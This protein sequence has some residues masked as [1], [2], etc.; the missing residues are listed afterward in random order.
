M[1]KRFKIIFGVFLASAV[2]L[3]AKISLAQD[4]G[5]EPVEST[6]ALSASDPRAIIGRIIQI[7]LSL[8]GVITLGLIIY[9][10]FLWMTSGGEEDKIRSAKN[11][12]RNAIIG[13]VIILSAWSITTFLLDRLMEAMTGGNGRQ[14]GPY[15]GNNFSVGLG[16]IGSCSV[17]SVYPE[18]NQ[19]DVPRNTSIIVTFK[20][21]IDA[22]S[23]CVDAS[24]GAC[25]CDNGA[26]SFINPQTIRIYKQELNDA[27]SN[28]CP[29]QNSNVTDVAVAISTDKRTLILSP[30]SYLGSAESNTDYAVKITSDLKKTDGSSMFRTCSA[31]ELI[32]G[33]EIG[34]RL[35]LTPPQVVSRSLFPRPDNAKDQV[36]AS[37]E[38][39]NA[40]AE[41]FVNNCPKI[42]VPAALNTVT[43]EAE[44]VL[45]YHG[46]I[47]R[48]MV[49]V[50][51]DDPN[52]AQL[53]N[54]NTNALLGVSEFNENNQVVFDGYFSLKVDGHEAGNSWEIEITPEQLADTLTVGNIKYIFA[55]TGENN[56]IIVRAGA[57]NTDNQASDI[58]AKISGHPDVN[59]SRTGSRV[60]LTAKVAGSAANG[61]TLGTSNNNA[62]GLTQFSGGADQRVTYTINDKK[63]VA[64][65][66]AIKVTFNEAVNPAAISGSASEVAAN[67]RLVNAIG[68]K[69]AG[70]ACAIN[71]ECL[72]YKCDGG[73]CVG[74]FVA[75]QFTV[76]NGY[77]TV[78]FISDNEC[79]INGCGEKVYCLPPN[80]N[81]ALEIKAADLKT[82]ASDQDCAAFSPHR[83]CTMGPLGYR[84][85]QDAGQRNYPLANIAA[86][87]GVTDVAFNSLDGNRDTAADGPIAYFNENTG[88]V[89]S[90]DS[91]KFSFFV[92]DQKELSS[93]RITAITP[94]NGQADITALTDPVDITFNTLM[95]SNTLRSGSKIINNGQTTTEHKF[96]NLKSA[97]ASP[98]GYWMIS[99]DKDVSP[100]D[101]VADLTVVQVKH[102]VF[103]ESLSYISQVG[104]GVKD[105]YQNC[106]KPSAGPS[107]E[108][109]WENPSCCFG[110]PSNTLDENG[111]CQ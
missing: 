56:N 43:P 28:S 4:F 82:C 109:T 52:R 31:S 36:G 83:T 34:S 1:L 65:N 63:D 96:I 97:A 40:T 85:C 42:F 48:F 87:S 90:K 107:C 21:E 100:L 41:I 10:G 78:E 35:D 27:C 89:D 11:I 60:S 95:M 92:N 44:V 61:L 9:A 108:A 17:Q 50:P 18:S 66:A 105:V 30:L 12:L 37:T 101:G 14:P 68:G 70:A 2:L 76:S 16:A 3:V 81:L 62:L 110:S 53:F 74:N 20:E 54:R 93:P 19:R 75:G 46:V 106:F 73:A 59:V 102:S 24:G 104:S 103:A 99:E 25:A 58:Q 8:L 22:S 88:A 69:S 57:C 94:S 13:L 77:K 33:F 98:L 67:I 23:A 26:C 6:I 80:S 84:T 49:S 38:S 86:L 32:W 72:S 15:V 79:G 45:N 111:N 7:V 5:L 64:M 47:N 29:A 39:A 91:Y 71:S 55:A 51:A